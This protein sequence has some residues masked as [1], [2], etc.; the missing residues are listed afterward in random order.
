MNKKQFACVAAFFFLGVCG[1]QAGPNELAL[2]GIEDRLMIAFVQ[3]V[4][5]SQQ[6]ALAQ[7]NGLEVL[8]VFRPIRAL[9]VKAP[10]G[11][12][13]QAET[14]L[15]HNPLVFRIERDFYTKWIETSALSPEKQAACVDA[16]LQKPFRAASKQKKQVKQTVGD[17]PPSQ[18][19]S[20]IQWGVQ[21]VNA[22][23]AWPVTQGAGVK[24]AI[25]DTGIDPEHPELKAN[26][27]G[28]HNA[29]D[30]D[31]PWADD[32]FHGT[33]VAGITAAVLNGE[34]VV[35]VAPQAEL[36]AVK[37]LS[38]DGS[39]SIFGIIGGIMWC[40]ENGM[41]V[42]NMSLGA[43]QGN[44]M[45]EYAIQAAYN[46]GIV[47]VAA[48]GNSG[49]AVGFPAAYKEAIAVS[50]LDE[51]DNI[52]SFSSRGPEVDFIAP[53]VKIPST[54][55]G[56]GI[57]A[58]SGTSM[59]TPHVTGLAALAVSRGARGQEAVMAALGAAAEQLPNLSPSEQGAG[60]V[61]AA[62][63]IR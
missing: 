22:S 42:I 33:H 4:P 44:F 59:A 5:E 40:I 50:A 54:V 10:A 11:R 48:A 63:L 43:D 39:G 35:G 41:D 25:V 13:L 31:Q 16:A 51:K 9:V 34:G 27:K 7:S 6:L 38:K 28:G 61:N 36:Y 18:P 37:V 3:G 57:A 15:K 58:Y 20:E 2:E 49:G 19:P 45:F 8:R 46:A 32:H 21:R 47:V 17:E 53:G 52:A 29:I 1:L 24:V 23:A 60:V 26:I 12:A 30:K 56:G 62:N 55:T 14:A